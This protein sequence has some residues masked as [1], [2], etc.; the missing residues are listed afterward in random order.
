MIADALT[1]QQDIVNTQN[2]IKY[3][4]HEQ[5]LFSS[6]QLDTRIVEE[7]KTKKTQLIIMKNSES[8]TKSSEL[9]SS[10]F[11]IE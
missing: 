10:I 9:T 4:Y 7:F 5:I 11:L 3:Q 8:S 2:T 6:K 1:R